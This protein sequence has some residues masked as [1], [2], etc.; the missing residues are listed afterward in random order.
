MATGRS[1]LQCTARFTMISACILAGTVMAAIP[2][3]AQAASN[4]CTSMVVGGAF[5]WEP[6]SYYDAMERPQGIAIDILRQYTQEHDIPL[7]VRFDIPWNRA[8]RM[9]E[10]GEIDAMA[11]A[12]FTQERDATFIYSLPFASDDIMVFQHVDR[13]FPVT[14]IE[15]L[16]GHPGARPQGGSY[17]DFIDRF[18]LERL[19]M[20]YS[21]TGNRIFDILLNGRVDY[22]LLGRYDGLA[23]IAKDGI[24][25]VMHMVEPPMIRNQVYYLFSKNSP[26][27]SHIVQINDLIRELDKTGRLDDLA[28]LHQP[29]SKNN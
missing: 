10:A 6:V 8:M 28:R 18:A 5:G 13:Q 7:Q 3:Y 15:N 29:A 24:E 14:S 25:D 16:I 23:N 26:C 17:G 19:D 2:N 27:V 20:I 22:V 9:L 12:Y 4:E 11:G 1:L 21:P